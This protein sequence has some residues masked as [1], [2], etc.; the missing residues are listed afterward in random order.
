MGAG[1]KTST[2]DVDSGAS[3]AADREAFEA[4]QRNLGDSLGGVIFGCTHDTYE[5]CVTG[6][7]F[8]LPRPHI[9]YVSYIKPGMPVFLYN[10]SDRKMHGIFRAT[11]EG[12]LDI[13]PQGWCNITGGYRTR[14][15]A[16]VKVEF[17]K[18]C[19]PL[20]EREFR[21]II[22]DC[23]DE[24]NKLVFE[25][26]KGE[27]AS[28]CRAFDAAAKAAAGS[29]PAGRPKPVVPAVAAGPAEVAGGKKAANFAPAPAPAT[30]SWAAK[31]SQAN[32]SSS[33]AGA[34]AAP[35]PAPA[36]Q[37]SSSKN[38][39]PIPTPFPT[40]TSPA[41]SAASSASA[42]SSQAVRDPSK[43][44]PFRPTQGVP[45]DVRAREQAKIQKAQEEYDA[46]QAAAAAAEEAERAR[47]AQRAPAQDVEMRANSMN[48]INDAPG[49][50]HAA[51]SS[52]PVAAPVAAQQQQVV[53]AAPRED[54]AAQLMALRDL[55]LPVD[56]ALA[57]GLMRFL[58]RGAAE[59]TTL[60]RKADQLQH[61]ND[62]LREEVMAM[63]SELAYVAQQVHIQVPAV[64][65][66]LAELQAARQASSGQIATAA[67]P[68]ASA[69]PW[70]QELYM[71]GGNDGTNWLNVMDIYTPAGGAWTSAQPMPAARG[72]GAAA[73]IGRNLYVMGGGNG[74]SWLQSVMCYAIDEGRWFEVAS[75]QEIRGSLAAASLNG[76]LYVMGGG[77][78][79]V[80]LDTAE[81]Y[82]P[83]IDA[84][85]TCSRMRYRRFTTAAA[86]MNGA[87]YVTGG[88]DG[89]QYL[90][91]VEMLDPR[92]GKWEPVPEMQDKR[93]SHACTVAHNML[94]AVGGWDSQAF[95]D[96]VEVYEPR[97]KTW[98]FVTSMAN[99]RA[100]GSTVTV[101]G[102]VYAIGGMRNQMHNETIERYDINTNS[103]QD[104][105]LPS[106]V[107]RKRAFL[108]SCVVNPR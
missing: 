69:G 5:E 43:P 61:E 100:Y 14:Y 62:I 33:S 89:S 86:V 42:S 81:V 94:F 104:L 107:A 60:S 11:T 80:N 30:N 79:N 93:G 75:M 103:W 58:A 68:A 28:M 23:Y 46:M 24:D 88:Y 35:A 92:E 66:A 47:A 7:I 38:Q 10:Y 59:R 97:M 55:L 78:P 63:R 15:P 53:P 17:Y 37:P 64:S 72:Y 95:L 57:E 31:L 9:C 32:G 2:Y 22:K 67:G 45:P 91:T 77:Q 74:E 96:S 99:S 44:N 34:P 25:L 41:P 29:L 51:S 18:Q 82:D 4:K 49:P 19:P 85:M 76:K 6:L 48:G 13:N 70:G 71:V 20:S 108:A 98:Q 50:S 21:P 105:L 16:Q 52:A 40:S 1:R 3:Y 106:N 56:P 83:A 12:Q 54:T 102:N 90:R 36:A 26:K 8:G 84:W 65:P 39:P 73:A 101:D 27:A 87:V